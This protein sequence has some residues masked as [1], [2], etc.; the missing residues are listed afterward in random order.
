MSQ[1]PAVGKMAGIHE[2]AKEAGVSASTVSNVIN[3]RD[4]RM[5]AE[6][7]QRVLVAIERLKFTPNSAARQLKSGQ[8]T[9]L[10]LVIPSA[11]NP[12]W[13]SVAHHVERAARAIGYRLLIC[14]AER[15]RD[16]EARYVETLLGSGIS[17][18]ILGSSP[19]D[20]DHLRDMMNRGLKVAA[21]DQR[22]GGAENGV[23]CSVSVDQEMG[24]MLAAQHLIGLGHSRIGIVIGPI[25]TKSRIERVNG[26][27]K[28]LG[29]A[30]LALPDERIWQGGDMTGFGD[31]EGSELGRVGIRELLSRDEPPTAV[32]CGN[33]MYALGAYAGARD[34]GYRVP[35]DV[36]IIGFDDIVLSQIVQPALTTIRQPVAAMSDLIVRLLVQ[37]VEGEAGDA[38]QGFVNVPPQLIVRASTAPPRIAR[39]A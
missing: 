22:V 2:V 21:F 29:R 23:A 26:V 17:G 30:R 3:G 24:G 19:L 33:D 39:S 27:R 35:D 14:N 13:G 7:R 12:F 15:D 4:D 16:V 10:G 25:K 32:F 1:R 34:L 28:A 37:R 8:N 5:R 38:T 20:F 36:S 6:T 31:M 18:V 11:A 9:T